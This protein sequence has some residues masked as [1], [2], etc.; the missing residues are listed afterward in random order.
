MLAAQE[1]I[2]GKR[3]DCSIQVNI[4]LKEDCQDTS[5]AMRQDNG[6]LSLGERPIAA[7]IVVTGRNLNQINPPGKGLIS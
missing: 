3:Q 6:Q 1:D 4:L 7:T 2:W 5:H